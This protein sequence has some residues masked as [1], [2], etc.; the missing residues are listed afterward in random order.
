MLLKMFYIRTATINQL[1]DNY[2]DL[3]NF[4]REKHLNSLIQAA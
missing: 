4:L 2:F 1:I 3:S